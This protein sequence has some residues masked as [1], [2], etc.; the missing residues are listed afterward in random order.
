MHNDYIFFTNIKY[1]LY[2]QNIYLS[3]KVIYLIKINM[4]SFEEFM[5]E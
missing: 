1:N 2:T 3:R 5:F 4:T